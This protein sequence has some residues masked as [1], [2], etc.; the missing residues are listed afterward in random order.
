VAR[1]LAKGPL[2]YP[3][4]RTINDLD[5]APPTRTHLA[6]PT[7]RKWEG[8]NGAQTTSPFMPQTPKPHPFPPVPSA[9]VTTGTLS[10]SATVQPYGPANQA[11][12][13]AMILAGSSMPRAQSSAQTSKSPMAAKASCT[14]T[15]TNALAVE[16]HPME[17]KGVL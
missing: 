2:H 9:L 16:T 6:A 4:L 12:V 8:T 14:T 5:H 15:N 1:D 7:R 13:D 11:Y 10:E 3:G 17:P